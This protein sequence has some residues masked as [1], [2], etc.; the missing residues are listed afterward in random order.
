MGCVPL[1]C[2]YSVLRVIAC[3]GLPLL[4]FQPHGVQKCKPPGYQSQHS[5]GVPCVNSFGKAIKEEWA[6]IIPSTGFT[7]LRPRGSTQLASPL[8]EFSKAGPC[9]STGSEHAHLLGLAVWC[10]RA[11]STSK[12]EGECKNGTYQLL[13]PQREFK[14]IPATPADA[15]RLANVSPSYKVFSTCC[16]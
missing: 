13:Y 8:A 6:R 12:V 1:C 10:H 4:S 5:R 14:Q 2:Q 16:F 7:G 3:Q 11:S 9:G 15:L